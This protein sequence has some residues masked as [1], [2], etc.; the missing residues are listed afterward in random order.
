MSLWQELLDCDRITDQGCIGGNPLLAF[1]YIH[2]NGLVSWEDYPYKGTQ[3]T[4]NRTHKQHPVATVKS[5][6]ILQSDHE[7]HM[8]LALRYVGPIAVGINAG[9]PAFLAYSGGIFDAPKCK[10]KANHALLI[11][12]YGKEV[13]SDGE[14]VRFFIARNSWGSGWGENGFIRIKRG[15]GHA[16]VPGVCGIARN[17]SVALGGVLLR[18]TD[19][20][21]NVSGLADRN[22]GLSTVTQLDRLCGGFGSGTKARRICSHLGIWTDSHRAFTLGVISVLCGLVLIWPLSLDVRRRRQRRRLHKI[23]LE[24]KRKNSL[25]CGLPLEDTPLLPAET[26]NARPIR[27]D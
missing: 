3:D 17:P 11:V 23:R 1:F 16:G 13:S 22:T 19:Y 9:S 25:R 18:D 20:V 7:K 10:Q 8:E 24:E 4:C 15:K 6:G 21:F 26:A 12:G 5:W 14:V 2:Q 27:G